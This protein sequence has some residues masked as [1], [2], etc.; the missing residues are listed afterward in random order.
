MQKEIFHFVKDNSQLRLIVTAFDIWSRNKI[1]GNGI[2]SFRMDCIKLFGNN[3]E[4]SIVEYTGPTLDV[5]KTKFHYL[6]HTFIKYIYLYYQ[7]IYPLLLERKQRLC[8][9][10][11]HNYYLQILTEIGIVGFFIISIIAFLF[12]AFV[13]KNFKFLKGSNIEN[14]LILSCVIS[15]FLEMF[16]FKNSGSIFSTYNI[17]YIVLISSIIL[18]YKKILIT[19]K[20]N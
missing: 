4:Y 5:V 19:K 11:P 14:F 7:D 6:N 20:N 12:L 9:N 3:P 17:A 13:F 10:H 2:K 15:L 16:P 18:S 8:S 1:L